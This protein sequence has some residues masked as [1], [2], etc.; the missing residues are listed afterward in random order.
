MAVDAAAVDEIFVLRACVLVE[1]FVATGWV[2]VVA[3]VVFFSVTEASSPSPF[4]SRS[5]D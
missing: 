5:S 1:S 3:G 4:S 2:F